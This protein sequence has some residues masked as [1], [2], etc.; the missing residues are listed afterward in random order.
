M[1]EPEGRGAAPGQTQERGTSDET[2]LDCPGG[3]RAA[4][5]VPPRSR[6][7]AR[8]HCCPCWPCCCIV[9][10]ILNSHFLTVSNITGIG[11]Q[12]SSLG[13][14]VVGESLILLI[15]G[16]DLSLE[17]TYG[18][19]PMLAAWLIVPVASFGSGTE[20]NPFLGILHVFASARRSA[21]STGC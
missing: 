20:L 19:A 18:L 5:R 11:Q 17:A 15:G 3:R 9:G 13:V 7:S 4:A 10:A 8:P 1:S 12:A 14:V 6:G 16:L 2:S 21:W